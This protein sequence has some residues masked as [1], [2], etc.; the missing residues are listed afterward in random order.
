MAIAPPYAARDSRIKLLQSYAKKKENDFYRA[1]DSR[2]EY[3]HLIAEKIYQLRRE[4]D[5]KRDQKKKEQEGKDQLR[6]EQ[7]RE[8]QQADTSGADV[9]TSVDVVN[10]AED[11]TNLTEQTG[12]T[13]LIDLIDLTD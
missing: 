8:E 11:L 9:I 7:K 3:Y 10:P 13:D 4:L 6:I 5:M 2:E 1:A 12:R